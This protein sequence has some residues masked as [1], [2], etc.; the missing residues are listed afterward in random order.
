MKG[1][2][3]GDKEVSPLEKYH[4]SNQCAKITEFQTI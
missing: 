4:N 2:F 3:H 1:I